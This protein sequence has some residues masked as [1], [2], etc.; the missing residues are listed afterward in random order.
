MAYLTNICHLC[1]IVGT[2]DLHR[3][4]QLVLFPH[5]VGKCDRS[6][7]NDQPLTWPSDLLPRY[8]DSFI[9]VPYLTNT[10]NNFLSAGLSELAWLND[11]PITAVS[12]RGY[13]SELHAQR[14]ISGTAV[15]Y[16]GRETLLIYLVLEFFFWAKDA[17]ILPSVALQ[18]PQPS[19][20]KHDRFSAWTMYH[21]LGNFP[22]PENYKAPGTINATS[23]VIH[24]KTDVCHHGQ[25]KV[26]DH[27][28]RWFAPHCNVTTYPR[29]IYRY[30]VR[31][32]G[33]GTDGL[34]PVINK[35]SNVGISV[36][37]RSVR[38]S[39]IA[40]ETQ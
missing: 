23:S 36:I 31:H 30:N 25:R 27:Y 8:H 15:K 33:G 22:N 21:S 20:D 29:C 24:V 19:S 35:T 40:V 32:T 17:F 5:T 16:K 14:T 6:Q 28:S 37:L 39:I 11:P 26:H 9:L 18:Q 1:N 12:P 34:M 4:W 38:V 2:I 7:M 10:I 13:G 3:Y